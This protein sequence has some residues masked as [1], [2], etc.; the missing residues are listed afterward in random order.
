MRSGLIAYLA[1]ALAI[2]EINMTVAPEAFSLP[3]RALF[4]LLLGPFGII[5]VFG[6]LMAVS[7]ANLAGVRLPSNQRL[8]AAM[9][10]SVVGSLSIFLLA[11]IGSLVLS[12][13]VPGGQYGPF[14]TISAV[15][16]ALSSIAAGTMAYRDALDI[17]EELE[18]WPNDKEHA[19]AAMR[20]SANA[21]HAAPRADRPPRRVMHKVTAGVGIWDSRMPQPAQWHDWL[22]YANGK[23]DGRAFEEVMAK[24]ESRHVRYIAVV[25]CED[26]VT[27][28]SSVRVATGAT[29]YILATDIVLTMLDFVAVCELQDGGA[30]SSTSTIRLESWSHGLIAIAPAC[31]SAR[32]QIEGN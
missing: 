26:R 31:R 4:A 17:L 11:S 9:I 19:G 7:I 21:L 1:C 12:D 6:A 22:V 15:V 18:L 24:L 3:F 27:H 29:P 13:P 5:T 14:A 28:R 10:A 25:V 32:A 8:C 20:R 30:A 2:V 16:V 23:C